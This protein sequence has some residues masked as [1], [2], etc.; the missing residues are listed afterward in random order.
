MIFLKKYTEIWYFL[1]AFWKY[2]LS[3]RYRA[4]TWSFLYHLKRWYFFLE[5][6][7]F[8]PWAESERRPFPGNTWKHD[9]SPS[10]KNTGTWYIGSK[11]GLSLNLSGWRY[12]TMNNL[13]C[14]VPFSPQGS[15][16]R[17]NYQ[18]C[19]VKK[20]VLRNFGKFTGNNC[21]RA[22][23]LIKMQAPATLLKKRP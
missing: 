1:Q 16:F 15:C 13:Q 9:T 5:N 3:K 14:L 20:C 6:M 7:I 18:G 21:P 11:F 19:F 4:G 23:F 22:S 2:G 12:S 8:L 17:G 10:E